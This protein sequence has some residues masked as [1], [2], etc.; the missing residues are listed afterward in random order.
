MEM[1]RAGGP[2]RKFRQFCKVSAGDALIAREPEGPRFDWRWAGGSSNMTKRRRRRRRS[3]RRKWRRQPIKED[4]LFFFIEREKSKCKEQREGRL[5]GG[6]EEEEGRRH[7]GKRRRATT[8]TRIYTASGN[9][10][11][12]RVQ[13]LT[14]LSS[15]HLPTSPPSYL[16]NPPLSSLPVSVF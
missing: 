5:Q 16:S 11:Q 1:T 14:S 10:M 8:Y 15:P 13:S 7:G 12:V 4:S 9:G 2:S 6:K 3:G